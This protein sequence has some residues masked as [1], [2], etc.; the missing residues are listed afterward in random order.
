MLVTYNLMVI[1]IIIIILQNEIG[2]YLDTK[3][4]T[5]KN[6]FSL[7]LSKYYIGFIVSS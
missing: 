5:P 6:L 7:Y 1:G 3:Y 4:A 2:F